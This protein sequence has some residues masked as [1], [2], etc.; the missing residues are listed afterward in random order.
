MKKDEFFLDGRHISKSD[1]TALLESAGFSRSNPYYIVMQ[2]KVNKLC[3]MKDR[4]RL[5]LLKEV[6]GTSVY[7]K[8]REESKKIM[9]ET[10]ARRTKI[11]EV[12][13][14][15]EKRLSEFEE[16]KEELN[17]YQNL[18]KQ[19]RALEYTLYDMD[20]RSVGERLEQIKEL[21]HKLMSEPAAGGAESAEKS[22]PIIEFADKYNRDFAE[23]EPRVGEAIPAVSAFDEQGQPLDLEQL[24]GQYAVLVFGCLT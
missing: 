6:A 14:Y 22:K 9:R 18:D 20:F 15:I 24:K 23:K 17:K 12:I 2:G 1:V 19:R 16:E 7:E 13:A 8:R 21:Q 10:N 4:E 11:D 5:D 3:H